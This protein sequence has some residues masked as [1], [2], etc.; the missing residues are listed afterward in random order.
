MTFAINGG[1]VSS[2]IR[3]FQPQRQVG[4]GEGVQRLMPKVMIHFRF[5]GSLPLPEE[6][7]FPLFP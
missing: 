7:T 2:A 6:T 5:F 3:L 4:R 1:E